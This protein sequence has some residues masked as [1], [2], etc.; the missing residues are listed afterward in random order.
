[1]VEAYISFSTAHLLRMNI[2]PVNGHE[3]PELDV[4]AQFGHHAVRGAQAAIANKKKLQC[5]SGWLWC[6]SPL[7]LVP[8]MYTLLVYTLHAVDSS[9]YK[10]RPL[11]KALYR[12]IREE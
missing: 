4:E 3:D 5:V 9:P 6:E 2:E 8:H 7:H 12:D 11:R 10:V 1:M